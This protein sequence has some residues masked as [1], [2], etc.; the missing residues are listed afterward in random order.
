MRL[1]YGIV[2]TATITHRFIQAVKTYGDEVCAIASRSLEKANAMALQ[3]HITKVYDNYQTMYGDPLVD[4]VYIATNNATHVEQIK[5]ALSH[6]KHVVVEKPIA[7]SLVEAQEVFALA[8]QNNCFLMEAQKS[9]F[10]PVTLDLKQIIDNQ[11]L[12]KLHQVEM[13]ASFANPNAPWM[14]DPN[15]GGVIYGSANYTFHYLDF[16]LQP[17][18]TKLQ[19]MGILEDTQ[20]CERVSLTLVMDDVLINSRISMNGL[21]QNHAIFYFENGYIRVPE[22][23]KARHYFIYEESVKREVSHPIEYEMIYEVEHIHHCIENKQLESAIM[24]AKRSEMCC[25]LV[26]EALQQVNQ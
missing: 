7:L 6:K 4:I 16:L 18:H 1:R 10:L 5:L 19:A 8:K 21:T 9:V 2:S 20:T 24:S 25:A 26:E 22:Y 23:W 11:T 17:Q 12:G 15:Q 14:H 13:S 3:Y